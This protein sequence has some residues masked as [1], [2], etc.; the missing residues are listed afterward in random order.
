M[1]KLNVR[2][3]QAPKKAAKFVKLDKMNV[4]CVVLA[5]LGIALLG[6]N[7]MMDHVTPAPVSDIVTDYVGIDVPKVL[8]FTSLYNV[9]QL[10]LRIDIMHQTERLKYLRNIE[11]DN[12]RHSFAKAYNEAA[13]LEGQSFQ[14][15][16]VGSEGNPFSIA[17]LLATA[18]PGLLIGRSLKRKQDYS[19]EE[20][21][22]LTR[23]VEERTKAK[24][25]AEMK[26]NPEVVV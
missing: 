4:T 25:I 6:C 5:V 14:D 21:K 18:A 13:R 3:N 9:N 10:K 12:L 24:V 26:S 19:P 23:K 15:V 8:G 1:G 16:V 2:D 11:D 7:T 17:G 22:K 20:V